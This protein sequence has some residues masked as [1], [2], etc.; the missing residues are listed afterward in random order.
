MASLKFRMA[1][2]CEAAGRPNNE[3]NYQLKDNLSDDNWGFT[4]DKEVD[5]GKKGALLVVADGMGGMNAGEVASA[6]AVETIKEYFSSEKLTDEILSSPDSIKKY[7]ERAVVAADNRIKD[8][9]RHDNEKRGMGST[10]VLAWI[11][12]GKVYVGWCGDSRAYRF[13]PQ[14]GLVQLS[15]DHSYVQELVDSGKLK[16]EF[17]FDHPDGNIITRSLGDNNTRVKPDI[18]DY[19]LRN[20]DVLLLCSD[21]LSGVLRD[22][23]IEEIMSSNTDSMEMCRDALWNTSK[24]AGWDDNVTIGICQILSGSRNPIENENNKPQKKSKKWII[25]LLSII[26]AFIAGGAGVFYC[27][28]KLKEKGEEKSE[29]EQL[30][31]SIKEEQ[32]KYENFIEGKYYNTL[33]SLVKVL[34]D[35]KFVLDSLPSVSLIFN[36]TKDDLKSENEKRKEVLLERIKTILKSQNDE[37]LKGIQESLK[38]GSSIVTSE[39]EN[40]LSNKE[41]QAEETK[42]EKAINNK[43]EETQKATNGDSTQE[44]GEGGDVTTE[45]DGDQDTKGGALTPL[46]L[47]DNPP[48]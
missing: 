9:G 47:N 24:D 32:D 7:I 35:E 15:R 4:T 45:G 14:D 17:A 11:M 34:N 6:I 5:L 2:R 27:M 8:E 28:Q 25:I 20:N 48:N 31:A 3:D 38:N 36:R 29:V 12:G 21:G 10:I 37:K 46:S 19:P 39:I 16:K 43:R 42:K 13:N 33:D 18:V 41:S 23:E 40:T 26:L 22:N 44:E 30:K 1:A